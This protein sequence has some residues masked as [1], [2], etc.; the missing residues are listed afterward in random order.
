MAMQEA[1]RLAKLLDMTKRTS[2]LE[3]KRLAVSHGAASKSG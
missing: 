1:M 2:E 3:K